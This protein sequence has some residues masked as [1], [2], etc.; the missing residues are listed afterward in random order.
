MGKNKVIAVALSFGLAIATLAGSPI[1]VNAEGG[2]S[3]L[4]GLP[5]GEGKPVVMV[6]YGNSRPDRPHYNLNQA[7]LIYVE[8]VEWGLT[9]IAAMF[10]TKFP[11]VVG[12]TRSARISDLE[13]L[14]QFT[15]PGL[16]YS[17]AN[18]VLLKAIRKS[19]SISLSPSDRSSFYYRNLSKKAPHNQLLRL[20]SMMAKETK[21]DAIK[22]I[23]LTFNTAAATG[24]TKTKS[25]QASWSSARVSGT[26]TGKKW[27]ISF[28]GSLHRDAVNK[29]FLTPKTI[30]LQYVERKL[31][32]YG[33]KF[34]GKTPLLKTV[35][36]GRAIVLR[37][38]QSFDGTWSRPTKEAGTIFSYAGSQLA[39]D[40]GQVMIVLVDGGAKKNP[41]TLK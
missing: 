27:I 10:N 32:K 31:T 38:G 15:K 4:S 41:V 2:P 1:S 11:S 20:S 21:V 30:V 26:W 33:D 34:G 23:G 5:G 39:F 9:R 22:D 17:G 40:V 7:D 13:L 16:A 29:S 25:F 24:G 12:P 18:D 6:K 8:E 3:P 14:E 28:D 36:A 37:N 35:G 19:Q